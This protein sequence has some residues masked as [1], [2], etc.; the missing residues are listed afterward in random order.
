M[1][2]F[3]YFAK[4]WI[5]LWPSS[6]PALGSSSL[7]LMSQ[8]K[9]DANRI[10]I[11]ISQCN[12]II[13]LLA[14]HCIISHHKRNFLAV[15]KIILPSRET[16]FCCISSKLSHSMWEYLR[17]N[18]WGKE[19]WKTRLSFP[20]FMEGKEPNKSCIAEAYKG[21]LKKYDLGP[22]RKPV[23]HGYIHSSYGMLVYWDREQKV[24]H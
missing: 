5:K 3:P 15:C 6:I 18:I 10:K 12:N 21:Q 4:F 8:R 22:Q 19:S 11:I 14:Q 2:S 24:Y 17:L 1:L 23:P 20:H 16:N 9:R 13:L 7:F